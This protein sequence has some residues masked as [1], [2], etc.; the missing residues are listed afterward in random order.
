MVITALPGHNPR[1]LV[2]PPW[3]STWLREYDPET[4]T[5]PLWNHQ[6]SIESRGG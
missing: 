5:M 4:G 2:D 1:D 3:L 6:I